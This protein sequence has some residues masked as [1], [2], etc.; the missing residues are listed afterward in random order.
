MH[1]LS[2]HNRPHGGQH[3]DA[4]RDIVQAVACQVP[5]PH[6]TSVCFIYLTHGCK[7][8]SSVLLHLICKLAVIAPMVGDFTAHCMSWGCESTDSRWLKIKNLILP[9]NL[10]I[11]NGKNCTYNYL[12]YQKIPV[13]VHISSPLRFCSCQKFGQQENTAVWISRFAS[14]PCFWIT[15]GLFKTDLNGSDHPVIIRRDNHRPAASMLHYTGN[16]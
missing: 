10:C 15:R 7:W 6:L 8:D 11:M 4:Q 5:M 2:K 13:D 9:G 16:R 1:L 12:W 3:P 14:Q